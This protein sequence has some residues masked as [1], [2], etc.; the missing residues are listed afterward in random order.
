MPV[1]RAFA[2]RGTGTV[3]TGTVWGGNVAPGA[4][5]LIQPGE[6]TARVRTV[7]SHGHEVA[8]AAAGQRAA[9]A[10]AGV[11]VSDVPRG[12]W[13]ST[14]RGWATT[15]ILRAVVAL[16]DEAPRVSPREWVRFHFG[17]AD[18]GARL[19]ARGGPIGPGERRPA[20]VVLQEPVLARAGDRFVIRR[21]SPPETIGGGVVIDPLPPRRRAPPWDAVSLE[22]G[23]GRILLEA[24]TTGV[25]RG[26]VAIRLGTDTWQA[27]LANEV[28]GRLY[29]P[30]VLDEVAGGIVRSIN[31]FHTVEPLSPGMPASGLA[32]AL[33]L[34]VELV[35]TQVTMLAA[36]GRIAR[37][38]AL[39]SRP[40]WSPVLSEA[41]LALKAALQEELVRAGPEPP[42]VSQLTAAHHRD[43]VPILRIMER[44][45]T[46]VAVESERFYDVEAVQG[47]LGLM[48]RE[49]EVGREY[50]PAE[51]R[52]ILGLSRKFL[53]PFLEFCDRMQ[54]TERRTTGRVLLPS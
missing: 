42:D 8:K 46:V 20:R 25:P 39:V 2:V 50:G 28:S 38:G 26:V 47:L 24:G 4:M 35:E 40:G 51:L 37:S 54:Y 15:T 13:L 3:V 30:E 1:D 22:E 27:A 43:P 18:T 34:P 9:I 6:R 5:V 41:D 52:E 33:R 32:G 11:E 45:G 29:S 44:E 31:E 14:D 17:T 48:R 49:M 10:L 36:A 53:I 23:L 12:S 16:D 21:S 19:V 7:Q